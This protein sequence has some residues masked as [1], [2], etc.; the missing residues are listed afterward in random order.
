MQKLAGAPVAP[1]PGL[2]THHPVPRP[3]RWGATPCW[4]VVGRAASGATR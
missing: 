4:G 2:P 3:P 1:H